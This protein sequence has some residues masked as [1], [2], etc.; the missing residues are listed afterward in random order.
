MTHRRIDFSSLDPM[1]D[2]ARWESRITRVADMAAEHH[3]TKPTVTEQLARWAL[4]MLAVAAAAALVA[5]MG[6]QRMSH[7]QAAGAEDPSVSLIAW[8]ANDDSSSS[9][10]IRYVGRVQ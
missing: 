8:A 1:R 4:P 3:R 2:A 7:A 5:G 6:L 10:V 9:A